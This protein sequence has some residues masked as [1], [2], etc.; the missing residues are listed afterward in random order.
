MVA[1]SV[2]GD[3]ESANYLIVKERALRWSFDGYRAAD[4][5]LREVLL[6]T[7]PSTVRALRGGYRPVLH[8]SAST[9]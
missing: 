2:D 8:P 9:N 6:L 7:M 4:A 3:V 5:S 1:A